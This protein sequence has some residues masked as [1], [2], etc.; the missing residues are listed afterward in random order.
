V[1]VDW[2]RPDAIAKLEALVAKGNVSGV[3]INADWRSS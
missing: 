3:R 2:T 1:Q